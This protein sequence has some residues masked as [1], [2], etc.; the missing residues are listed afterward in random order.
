MKKEQKNN[1]DKIQKH[2]VLCE[3]KLIIDELRWSAKLSCGLKSQLLY[4]WM[5]ERNLLQPKE[6]KDYLA[7]YLS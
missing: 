5:H 4:F 7:C 3:P 6:D 1:I 2:Y